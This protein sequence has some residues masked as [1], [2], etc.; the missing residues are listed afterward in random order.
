MYRGAQNG[1]GGKPKGQKGGK[2][3]WWGKDQGKGW[4]W[5]GKDQGKGSGGPVNGGVPHG[6]AHHR[7]T[8]ICHNFTKAGSCRLG[9]ACKFTHLEGATEAERREKMGESDAWR[10]DAWRLEG[11]K[12]TGGSAVAPA[13]SAGRPGGEKEKA[14]EPK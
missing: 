13:Q 10:Y 6:G 12:K 8:P 1:D 14:V 2:D 5:W 7:Q 3:P 4:S 11:P 9:A